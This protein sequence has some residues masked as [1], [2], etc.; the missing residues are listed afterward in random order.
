M[1]T[2]ALTGGIGSGKTAV[3]EIFHQLGSKPDY[4]DSVKIIDADIIARNLLAGSLYTSPSEALKKVYKLFGSD[5]FNIITEQGDD[6]GDGQLDRAKLRAL[7]F[8]SETRKKQLEAILHPL[9]YDEIF[10][11]INTIKKENP[12]KNKQATRIV[13]VAIPLLFE[14]RSEDRFDRVLVI[15]VPVELQIRRSM[16]RDNCSRELVEQ[17]INSQV[18]RQTRLSQANDVIDNSTTPAELKKQVEKLFQ[19]YQELSSSA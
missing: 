8:S 16:Q 9:V 14:T 10:T 17:I 11:Q 2:V 3:T 7:I 18:D 5:L 4:Q 12:G 15:D 19:Y 13:I 1:L 6:Q